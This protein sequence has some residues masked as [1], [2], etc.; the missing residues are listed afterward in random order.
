[1]SQPTSAATG[2][3]H[4]APTPRSFAWSLLALALLPAAG[5]CRSSCEHVEAELRRRETELHETRDELE[6]AQAINETLQRELC[7]LRQT[8][9][10]PPTSLSGKAPVP[11]S[12]V[13][14]PLGTIKDIALSRQ[15][16]GLDEDRL[17]GDEALQVVVEPRDYDGHA[18]KVHG[19]LQVTALEIL[20]E[21][22]KKPLSTWEVSDDQLRRSW[23]TGLFGS[24]FYVV[25]P[26]Q[27][28]PS[29]TKLR[30]IVRFTQADG[31]LFEADRDV[32]VRL[33]PI[34]KPALPAG[35]EVPLTHRAEKPKS[36]LV[37]AV[38]LGR[39]Q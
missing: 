11:S 35:P 16:G 4:A 28:P 14:A 39:P 29:A 34:P 22:V 6:R 24:G 1:M 37:G 25:L 9:S 31:R 21:G 27:C 7:A 15:T 8:P 3:N 2:H 23:K 33:L 30:V 17:P 10:P 19:Q 13:V 5:G 38:Q 12:H 32:T 18:L 26:W 36:P 20:P